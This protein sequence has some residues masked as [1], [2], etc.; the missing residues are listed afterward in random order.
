LDIVSTP[1]RD[2]RNQRNQTPEAKPEKQTSFPP[3]VTAASELSSPN[4]GEHHNSNNSK[5]G[6][7]MLWFKTFHIV[8]MVSWYA[9]L[10]M[11]PRLMVYHVE[12]SDAA[13]RAKFAEWERRTY[14]LGHVAF[15]LMLV[16]GMAV[17]L[18]NVAMAP[19]YMKQGWLHAKLALVTLQFGYFIYCGILTKQLAANRC[20]KTSRW[21]RLFN[22]VPAAL[23]LAIVAL[24]IVKPF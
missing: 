13:L 6:I 1:E 23:L 2:A 8:F 22:E 4:V 20:N 16:F 5:E 12:T 17:L 10:F 14:L 24:V 15:G 7:N 19:L 18:G 21:L 11:L 9:V 3:T